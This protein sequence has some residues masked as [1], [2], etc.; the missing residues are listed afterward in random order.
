MEPDLPTQFNDGKRDRRG[1]FLAGTVAPQGDCAGALYRVDNSGS[2]SRL[3]GGLGMSNG[4]DW[5]PGRPA[6]P[7]AWS[8]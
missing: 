7:P 3:I 4:L 2:I 8:P 5:S 1:R 6:I